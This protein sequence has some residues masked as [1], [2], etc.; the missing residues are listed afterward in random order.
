MIFFL[1][2]FSLFSIVPLSPDE[3]EFTVDSLWN[4]AYQE[5]WNADSVEA[6]LDGAQHAYV[7][8]DPFDSIEARNAI[9]EIKAKGNLVG[10]YMSVGTGE[11]WREDFDVLKNSL[12]DKYWGEWPGEF[13]LD[14]VNDTVMSVMKA[15]ID[16]ISDWGVDFVEFDNMDW[17]FDDD[18]R[19][20]YKFHITIEESLEYVNQLKDYASSRGLY[21]MAKNMTRGVESFAGVTY[22]SAPGNREWWNPEDLKSFLS[23]GK[24]CVVFHYRE[25]NQL[26]VEEK[27][28]ERYDEN[29]LVLYET[30]S[31]RG[32]SH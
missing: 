22:E 21:C 15:R 18:A 4:Q 9:R 31:C 13:F 23:E 3:Y 30:R 26:K 20:K 25:R 8:L 16:K 19:R 24:L 11:D 28:R 27:Y 12:V 6:I 14:Q 5:N 32:Y 1:F 7:L 29:L 10:A 2:I 17:A